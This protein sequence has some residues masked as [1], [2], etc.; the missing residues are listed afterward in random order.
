SGDF[1]QK[2]GNEYG[3]EV[4][5]YPD[6]MPLVIQIDE[7]H[8]D[9]ESGNGNLEW[10]TYYGGSDLDVIDR[11]VSND[12]GDTWFIGTTLSSDFPVTNSIQGVAG[13][14]DQ[15]IGKH[16]PQENPQWVTY[17]GGD[18]QEG[19]GG[20]NRKGITIDRST[21]ESYIASN[22]QSNQS[23]LPLVDP[24][25]PAYFDPVNGCD[26]APCT[27]VLLGK[28]SSSGTLLWGTMF[29]GYD[30]SSGTGTDDRAF[31]CEFENG[32]FYFVGGGNI[33]APLKN[34]IS[35]NG[36]G[37]IAEFNQD[38]SLEFSTKFGTLNGR[39]ESIDI[40]S[41]KE[42]LISGVVIGSNNIP[43]V[44]PGGA[45]TSSYNGGNSDGFIATINDSKNIVWSTHVGGSN[46]EKFK[47]AIYDDQGEIIVVGGTNSMDY[48]IQNLSSSS[49]YQ[50]N[51]SGGGSITVG[52]PT[53]ED[54]V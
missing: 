7:G 28:F 43:V 1:I 27:D 23:A 44:N 31:D 46:E 32:S 36:R 22:T 4:G 6:F 2:N 10:S 45:Y 54:A 14:A 17:W 18:G 50:S 37:W 5:N 3:I 26:A 51:F 8:R 33:N 11:T 30:P 13:S 24:G 21:N 29:G 47:D 9:T 12:R 42:I 38:L 49:F 35:N 15:I 39:I 25:A 20:F 53:F 19:S 40:N 48:T 16:S 52:E 41:N 34:E